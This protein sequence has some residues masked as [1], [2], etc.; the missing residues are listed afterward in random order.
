ML[1][2]VVL[3]NLA[4]MLW[5]PNMRAPQPVAETDVMVTQDTVVPDSTNPPITIY[6]RTAPD[7]QPAPHITG[8]DSGP[9]Q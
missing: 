2:I 5:L 1:T 7:P 4:L 6:S 9:N 3:V 8:A